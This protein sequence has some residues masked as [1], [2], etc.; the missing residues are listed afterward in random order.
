M[1]PFQIDNLSQLA[2]DVLKISPKKAF[3]TLLPSPIDPVARPLLETLTVSTVLDRRPTD[4]DAASCVLAALWLWHDHL[5]PAHEIV[6]RVND[7]IGSYWHGIV[8]RREGDFSNAKYWFARGE[9]D[10]IVSTMTNRAEDLLRSQPADKQLFRIT[11]NGW[12]PS[13]FV[14][15]ASRVSDHPTDPLYP[16]AVAL[17]RMEWQVLFDHCVRLAVTPR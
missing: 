8:H 1:T 10:G 15:L 3:G 4:T 6:Q 14:D 5:D 7:E 13:A 9:V 2:R 12:N 17:Q 11:A 16:L